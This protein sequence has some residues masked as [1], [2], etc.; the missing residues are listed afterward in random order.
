MIFSH[1][2]L[3][4]NCFFPTK[5]CAE[6]DMMQCFFTCRSRQTS[7]I[8]YSSNCQSYWAGS[9]SGWHNRIKRLL[10]IY[11]FSSEEDPSSSTSELEYVYN[12]MTTIKSSLVEYEATHTK[13]NVNVDLSRCPVH[14]MLHKYAW[15]CRICNFILYVLLQT[16]NSNQAFRILPESASSYFYWHKK[17]GGLPTQ[18]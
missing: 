11:L 18:K 15:N 10:C 2:K 16:W 3:I 13:T 9:G 5:V 8:N 4:Q 7:S 12:S 1:W 14:I 17:M 6:S